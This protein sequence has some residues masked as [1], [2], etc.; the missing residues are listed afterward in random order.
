[1]KRHWKKVVAALVLLIAL[2]IGGSWF[3]AKVIN[4]A[5][6]KFSSA[7]LAAALD[8][9]LPPPDSSAGTAPASS[10][11]RATND[12]GGVWRPVSTSVVRYRVDESINGFASTAVGSTNKITGNVTI[13]ANRVRAAGFTVDTGSFTSDESRRDDQVRGRVLDAAHIPTATFNITAPLEIASVPADGTTV[14]ITTT[15][16][17][18][19]RG[20]TKSVTFDLLAMRKN[21]KIGIIGHI[22]IAFADYGIPNPS[23]GTIKTAD[24]GVLEF[25]V[26]LQRS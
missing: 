12:I 16:N 4:K 23:F 3:Y 26:V 6:S 5:P 24:H 7:D 15:G 25:I 10:V 8:Q 14:Q 13:E 11:P 22:P 17:L 9:P 2:V 18:M 20:T 21:G 1:M 19:L